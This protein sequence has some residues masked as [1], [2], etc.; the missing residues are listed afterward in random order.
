VEHHRIRS[1]TNGSLSTSLAED[2]FSLLHTEAKVLASYL[3]ESDIGGT[4]RTGAC[5][6]VDGIHHLLRT[7]EHAQARN[8]LLFLTTLEDTC[9][10]AN[11]FARMSVSMERFLN[12]A[13]LMLPSVKANDD[14][15]ERLG[16]DGTKLVTLFS[17]DAVMASERTQVFIMRAV[18]RTSIASDYFSPNW[19]C[20][21]TQNEVTEQMVG[22]FD[23]YLSR[24]ERYFGNAYLYSKALVVA[25]KAM[26]CFYVRCLIDKADSV[27]R[28]RRNRERIGLPGEQQPFQSQ[29]RALRR[30]SDD[31]KTMQALFRERSAGNA[32]LVRIIANE[33]HVLELIHECL[34]TD[35]APSLESFI[36]VIHKRTGADPLV[37]RYFVGDLWMLTAHK[38][39]RKYIQK[40]VEQLQPDLKMVT[41]GMKE[42]RKHC[43]NEVSFARLDEMLKTLYEDRV[44]QGLLP[45]CWACL[46]KV[47]TEGD[48]VVARRIRDFTRKVAE[49]QLRKKP[50]PCATERHVMS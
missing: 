2:V 42:Q 35:D 46:P 5:L 9:A 44:A 11:D 23:E 25:A 31:I 26:T 14:L 1:D 12:D 40:A 43:E 36:V 16:Q 45:A 15:L 4:S 50:T 34:D 21:W 28:R 29:S 30:I 8:R 38:R 47:E 17:L 3:I 22:I 39:G 19:E 48:K 24:M 18:Q 6:F 37:T 13:Q 33:M 49:L 10:A 20:E 27:T 41:S 7:L 32:T